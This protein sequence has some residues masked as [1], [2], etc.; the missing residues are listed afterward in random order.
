M[1]RIIPRQ[2]LQINTRKIRR[3]RRRR[4]RIIHR[5]EDIHTPLPTWSARTAIVGR[6]EEPQ[7]AFW[8]EYGPDPAA[9]QGA[10]VFH[11]AAGGVDGGFAVGKGDVG[12]VV[13]PEV[14]AV[15]AV[16]I[17]AIDEAGGEGAGIGV[18]GVVLN[19][20][21]TGVAVEWWWGW[22]V[23]GGGEGCEE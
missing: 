2:G 3:I 7:R 19:F 5:H 9:G 12:L 16:D 23:G 4:S 8:G 20:W 6:Q 14:G 11:F 22:R 13:L 10:R 17:D 21:T 1:A 18:V 15:D